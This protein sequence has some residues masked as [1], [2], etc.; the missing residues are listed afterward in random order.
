MRNYDA[1]ELAALHAAH[2]PDRIAPYLLATGSL[3]E[4]FELYVWNTVIASRLHGALQAVEVALRNACHRELTD[5]ISADWFRDEEFFSYDETFAESFST[6]ET[7]LRNERK[8]LTAASVIAG[9][10]FGFWTR[11]FDGET[12]LMLWEPVLRGIFFDPAPKSAGIVF[13]DLDAL[14]DLRNRVAH[15]KPLYTMSIA[16]ELA[17]IERVADW[18]D[19]VLAN[20]IRRFDPVRV[21]LADRPVPEL[22][23]TRGSAPW[24]LRTF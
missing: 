16:N 3:A 21:A 10:P 1:G 2:S 20:W 8:R 12:G 5:F 6:V 23:P 14:R 24:R 4:A 11:L 22:D 18:I 15:Y 17:R 13:R 19:P 7:R 9:Y